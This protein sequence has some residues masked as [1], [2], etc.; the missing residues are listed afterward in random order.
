MRYKLDSGPEHS[1]G[2][3]KAGKEWQR[4]GYAVGKLTYRHYYFNFI[5]G[6]IFFKFF[7]PIPWFYACLALLLRSRKFP[8]VPLGRTH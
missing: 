1:M 4:L 8:A 2:K 5:G 6:L 7:V 3:K